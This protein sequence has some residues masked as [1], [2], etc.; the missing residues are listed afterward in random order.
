MQFSIN[1]VK[2]SKLDLEQVTYYNLKQT[3]WE[4]Y[5]LPTAPICA[6]CL[7]A[8]GGKDWQSA[9]IV[10]VDCQP[11]S[12]SWRSWAVSKDYLCRLPTVGKL[13]LS[14]NLARAE[15]APVAVFFADC[16]AVWQSAKIFFVFF[17]AL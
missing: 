11:A 7:A 8:A 9:K 2:V 3:L 15:T 1:L 14:A 4:N 10:F 5:S 13:Q 12:G 16:L 17:F 6:D